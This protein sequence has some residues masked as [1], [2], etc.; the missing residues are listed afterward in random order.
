MYN[1]LLVKQTGPP[2]KFRVLRYRTNEP[3]CYINLVMEKK[4]CRA[5]K[6]VIL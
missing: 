3:P 4:K 1:G 2:Q 6:I 5:S